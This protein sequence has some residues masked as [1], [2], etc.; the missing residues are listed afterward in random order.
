MVHVVVVG[1]INM[2]LVVSA[3]RIPMPG[4]TVLGHGF[5]TFPGGKGANQAVA[6]ARQG[7]AV[8]FIGCIGV[9]SF[10]EELLNGLKAEHIETR[11]MIVSEDAPSGV[12][13]ITLDSSGQNSIV[14][15]SG[16]NSQLTSRQIRQKAGIFSDADVLL[17]QLET[18]LGTMIAAAEQ[19]KE[20]NVIVVLNPA[21]AQPLPKELLTL[22]DVLV[23][24]ES[25][26]ALLTGQPVETMEQVKSGALGLIAQGVASVVVTLGSRGAFLV[27][28]DG[29][30]IH[31]PSF[32]VDV[33]DTTAAG[34]SFVGAFAV[35]LAGGLSLEKAVLRGCAAGA[36]ATTR[37]GAQPS[38][39]TKKAVDEL[40]VGW[41]QT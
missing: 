23:P 1:S 12:A 32:P 18:P 7:A 27:M 20:K 19:A 10:G 6:A 28:E 30:A 2:D 36:L 16:A 13:L 25:E 39:P 11:N 3:E 8:S 35:A 5:N 24:N 41:R 31:V 14:V 15:A 4:E 26:T 33:I 40:I 38:I 21:P 17:L 29:S 37:L 9:D 34:D 22:V